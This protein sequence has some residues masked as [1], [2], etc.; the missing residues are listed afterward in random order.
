MV[1]LYQFQIFSVVLN[2]CLKY[3]FLCI[4]TFLAPLF[5]LILGVFG[6][7]FGV[8]FF[9]ICTNVEYILNYFVVLLVEA[10]NE[11]L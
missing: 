1:E 6:G 9:Q 4:I 2:W 7:V 8:F 10:S 5:V 3:F 11:A